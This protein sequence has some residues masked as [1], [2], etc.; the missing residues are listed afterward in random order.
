MNDDRSP[1]QT[2][3]MATPT[4]QLNFPSHTLDNPLLL[5]NYRRVQMSRFVSNTQ[6]VRSTLD[7]VQEFE[8]VLHNVAVAV[9]LIFGA[10][11]QCSVAFASAFLNKNLLQFG[12][13]VWHIHKV[14]DGSENWRSA[15]V[16]HTLRQLSAAY[17]HIIEETTNSTN[18][19]L[20]LRAT[21]I[22]AMM[23]FN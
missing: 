15:H 6:N 4:I 10:R 17:D 3:S 7:G 19:A 14:F 20:W 22:D 5:T 18:N 23:H 1:G 13:S 12:R 11:A 8:R 21:I 16:P 2:A 9:C